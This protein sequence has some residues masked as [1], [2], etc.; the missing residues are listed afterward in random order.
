MILRIVKMTFHEH[1]LDDFHQLFDQYKQ[2]IR[3]YPGCQRL[4]LHSDPLQKGVRYTY[5]HWDSSEA[6]DAYRHSE[7][8]A[9]VWPATK[10]LFAER[11]LAH[12]LLLMEEISS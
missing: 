5:S 9:Q 11:P 1:Y 3:N 10:R 6:L 12:S 4:A 8:F 2:Q 7:L